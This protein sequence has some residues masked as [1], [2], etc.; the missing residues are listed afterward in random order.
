VRGDRVQFQPVGLNLMP[1]RL[2][3]MR[4]PHAGPRTLIRTARDGG[5]ALGVTV[6]D[7]G[8]GIAERYPRLQLTLPVDAEGAR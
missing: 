1:N 4:E 2:D 7:S 6:Q 5:A 3:A 8:S